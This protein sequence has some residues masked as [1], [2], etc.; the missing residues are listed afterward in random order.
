MEPDDVRQLFFVMGKTRDHAIV[1]L[2]L[3]R[4]GTRIRKLFG[5]VLFIE[6]GR[7]PGVDSELASAQRWNNLQDIALH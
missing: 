3:L 4:T 2:M 6:Q 5:S 1:L 7:N